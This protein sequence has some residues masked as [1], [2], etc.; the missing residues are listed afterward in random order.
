MNAYVNKQKIEFPSATCV[1]SLQG[2]G[3]FAAA[4][5]AWQSLLKFAYRALQVFQSAP[6]AAPGAGIA[7]GAV[8][9]QWSNCSNCSFDP[10]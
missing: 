8:A 9:W 1:G 6:G 3:S 10:L 2:V 7:D 4:A 5:A